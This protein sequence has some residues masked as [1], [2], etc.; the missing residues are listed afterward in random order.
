MRISQLVSNLH[1][2]N[3]RGTQ[4]IYSHVGTLADGLTSM[5]HDVHLFAAGNSITQAKLHGFPKTSLHQAEFL[6]EIKKHYTH[7][8]ISQCFNYASQVDIIHS[9]FTLLS[10]F[11]A[12]LVNIPTINSI[13]SPITKDIKPL[14][15]H[16]RNNR[17]ISFSIAQRKQVP[18]LNWIANIYHGID[19]NRFAYNPTS[20]DYFLYI[21]RITEEKGV[22]LAIEAAKAAGV[23]LVIAGRSYPTEG[24]WHNQIEPNIDGE[25]ITY[26]GEADMDRKI[27][28]FQKAKGLL[29]PTQYDE[30]FGLVMIEALSCGTPVIGWRSGSVPEVVKDGETGYVVSS[31]DEMVKAIKAVGKISRMA[32]RKRAE[33]YFSNAKMVSG[34]QKVYERIINEWQYQRDKVLV[35]NP[36][37]KK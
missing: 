1:P 9:H 16:F 14:L 13:H 11:Y 28:L 17:Y 2:V 3:A 30:V 19:I 36:W 24:Y 27:D 22:H 8:L 31:I 37:N 18:E 23:K 33:L 29:F 20:E 26:V 6:P 7:F 10:S 15:H 21:G 5:G 35:T 34:Y 12:N 32:C 25:Q 4:A